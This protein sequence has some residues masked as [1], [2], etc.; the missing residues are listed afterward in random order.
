MEQATVC[1]RARGYVLDLLSAGAAGSE[2]DLTGLV[3]Q[4]WKWKQAPNSGR[5][6]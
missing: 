1:E 4:A 2:V 3:V 6:N 5:K